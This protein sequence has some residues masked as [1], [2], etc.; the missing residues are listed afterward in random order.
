MILEYRYSEAILFWA[1]PGLCSG[2]W[3]ILHP[4]SN[5]IMC[6]WMDCVSVVFGLPWDNKSKWSGI[7]KS[8]WSGILKS[9]WSDILR[10][11]VGRCSVWCMDPLKVQS[12]CGLTV[13]RHLESMDY[14]AIHLSWFPAV[15]AT[16]HPQFSSP[17]PYS[18]LAHSDFCADFMRY[19]WVS[20][21]PHRTAF[22]KINSPACVTNM[23]EMYLCGKRDVSISGTGPQRS[24]SLAI[25]AGGS[26][27]TRT[28][29][30]DGIQTAW[31]RARSV[32]A[33]PLSSVC[34]S[35]TNWLQCCWF[36]L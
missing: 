25:S 10:H 12:L 5:F 36:I 30:T 4:F 22:C 18:S 17:N 32:S 11:L 2:A 31:F 27:V 9:D 33:S 20:A 35:L 16:Q 3:L 15:Y 21:L 26:L 24:L 34:F 19:F 23:D 13:Y 28:W 14:R 6:L 29:S 8:D 1:S 7:L